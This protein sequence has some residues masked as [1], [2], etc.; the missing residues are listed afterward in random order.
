MHGLAQG[1]EQEGASGEAS[2]SGRCRGSTVAT[3]ILL[4]MGFQV[5]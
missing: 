5:L 2:G 4:L 3:L 1:H